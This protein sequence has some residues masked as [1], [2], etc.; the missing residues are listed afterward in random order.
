MAEVVAQTGSFGLIGSAVRRKLAETYEMRTIDIHPSAD[1]VVDLSEPDSIAALDLT[2]CSALVHCAGIVDE[3]FANTG[4]AFRQATQGM[5]E[6]VARAKVCGVSRF[7]YISSAHVYGP[8]VGAINEASPP[9]PLSDYAIA[10]FASEQILRRASGPEF[11]AAVFRPCAVFGIPPDLA[12]FR[13]WGFIP[14]GFPKSLVEQGRIELKSSGLQ[15]RN[16]VGTDDIAASIA[17]WLGAAAEAFTLINPVGNETMT[18]WDFARLCA[19]R[20]EAMS[21]KEVMLVR[22]GGLLVADTYEYTT[23]DPRYIGSSDLGE[24]A[25]KLMAMLLGKA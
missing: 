8:M 21:A 25:S 2:G 16:F 6:L 7:A 17:L 3:D 4:R 18:V 23:R 1:M 13:R 19:K 14:F 5:A 22:P 15:R 10:H 20:Y 11:R 24:T 9:N 12:R